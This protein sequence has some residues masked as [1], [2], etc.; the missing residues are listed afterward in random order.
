M[1][2]ANDVGPPLTAERCGAGS[3]ACKEP[4]ARVI[5]GSIKTAGLVGAAAGETIRAL[6]LSSDSRREAAAERGGVGHQERFVEALLIGRE[7]VV[8][9]VA[10]PDERVERLRL[11]S[12]D[13]R[14]GHI[15]CIDVGVIATGAVEAVA[16]V[17]IEIH[18]TD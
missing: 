7:E 1:Q 9:V 3:T 15:A 14:P 10:T 5:R 12:R 4:S 2:R 13:A 6:T 8:P 18:V 17:R 11:T 16:E